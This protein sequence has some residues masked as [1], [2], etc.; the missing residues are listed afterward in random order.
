MSYATKDECTIAPRNAIAPAGRA[1]GADIAWYE[2]VD[3]SVGVARIGPVRMVVAC[4]REHADPRGKDPR[5][6]FKR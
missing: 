3:D 1:P 4:L 6:L 2:T 5:T